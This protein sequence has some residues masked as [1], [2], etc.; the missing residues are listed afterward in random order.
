MKRKFVKTIYMMLLL[1]CVVGLCGCSSCGKNEKSK[2]EESS[3]DSESEYVFDD[4][5]LTIN[6]KYKGY[7]QNGGY[8][9]LNTTHDI[10]Q[11]DQFTSDTNYVEYFVQ[12]DDSL[13]MYSFI[14]GKLE[15]VNMGSDKDAVVKALSKYKKIDIDTSSETSY[16]NDAGK[17]YRYITKDVTTSQFNQNFDFETFIQFDDDLVYIVMI[18]EDAETTDDYLDILDTLTLNKTA[19]AIYKNEEFFQKVSDTSY[20]FNLNGYDCTISKDIVDNLSNYQNMGEYETI[21]YDQYGINVI[22]STEKMDIK[23]RVSMIQE[24]YSDYKEGSFTNKDGY[25]VNY[26]SLTLNPSDSAPHYALASIDTGHGY[27]VLDIMGYKGEIDLESVCN[28]YDIHEQQG[29]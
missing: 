27:V 4:E 13:C 24:D 21:Y 9:E 10:E 15:D 6:N 1:C 22:P 23:E 16:E 20:Q 19:Y 8:I 18:V 3:S 12:D 7:F 2:S 11:I 5:N 17:W 28:G 14:A 26:I 25:K 29:E